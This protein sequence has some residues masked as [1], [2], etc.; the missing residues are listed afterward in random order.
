MAQAGS[1]LFTKRLYLDRNDQHILNDLP[2]S[3]CY[4]KQERRLKDHPVKTSMPSIDILPTDSVLLRNAPD[5]VTLSRTIRSLSLRCFS[6][7]RGFG[8]YSIS[9]LLNALMTNGGGIAVVFGL[10]SGLAK[11]IEFRRRIV[12]PITAQILFRYQTPICYCHFLR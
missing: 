5:I 3:R 9:T 2:F 12:Q 7:K 6:R 1:G 11:R 4:K 8:R 10:R